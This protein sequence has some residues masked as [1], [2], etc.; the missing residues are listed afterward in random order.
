MVDRSGSN[1]SSDALDRRR[2]DLVWHSHATARRRDRGI[3]CK[4]GPLSA[5]RS[6]TCLFCDVGGADAG[7]GDFVHSVFDAC[8]RARRKCQFDR[9]AR[10]VTRCSMELACKVSPERAHQG[11]CS[12]REPAD[13]LRK[14]SD[15][16]DGWLLS[17]TFALSLTMRPWIPIVLCVLMPVVARANPYILNPSSLLAFGVVAF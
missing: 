7:N 17:L 11:R 9:Y 15:I 1:R 3:C 5:E 14:K 10:G 12:E 4:P 2:V 6:P 16:I 8:H 13:S